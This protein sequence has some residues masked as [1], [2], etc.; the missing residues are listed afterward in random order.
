MDFSEN[1]SMI[2]ANIFIQKNN[3]TDPGTQV[4]I[5]LVF[6][7]Y[8]LC[9]SGKQMDIETMTYIHVF[10]NYCETVISSL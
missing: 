7:G 2:M 10:R 6:E 9:L 1:E 3:I 4:C 5:R 8:A